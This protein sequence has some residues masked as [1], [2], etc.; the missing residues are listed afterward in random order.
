MNDNKFMDEARQMVI[1]CFKELEYENINLEL[2]EMLA[3][4]LSL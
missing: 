4:K 2:A 1:Y 3:T